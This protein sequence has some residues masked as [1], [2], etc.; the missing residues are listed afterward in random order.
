MRSFCVEA[1]GRGE[2]YLELLRKVDDANEHESIDCVDKLSLGGTGFSFKQKVVV[3]RGRATSGF[4]IEELPTF[5]L[6]L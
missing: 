4:I 1:S 3:N 6:V 5:F 2:M